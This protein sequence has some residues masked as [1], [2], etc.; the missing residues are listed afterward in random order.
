MKKIFYL[1]V[2]VFTLSM[3]C[4]MTVNAQDSFADLFGTNGELPA[5]PNVSQTN[6]IIYREGYRSS[7]LEM[8]VFD[9]ASNGDVNIVWNKSLKLS[10]N[11]KYRNDCKFYYDST[12]NEWIKFETGYNKISD[13]ATSVYLSNL[14]IY[15]NGNIYASGKDYWNLGTKYEMKIIGQSTLEVN[16]SISLTAECHEHQAYASFINTD[17]ITWSCTDSKIIKLLPQG[18]VAY[19]KALKPGTATITATHTASGISKSIQILVKDIKVE[20]ADLYFVNKGAPH[21]KYYEFSLKSEDEQLFNYEPR[22]TFEITNGENGRVAEIQNINYQNNTFELKAIKEGICEIIAKF[23]GQEKARAKIVV[24]STFEEYFAQNINHYHPFTQ[25]KFAYSVAVDLFTEHGLLNNAIAYK[26]IDNFALRV[27]TTENYNYMKAYYEMLLLSIITKQYADD[28]YSESLVKKAFGL[29]ESIVGEVADVKLGTDMK[30]MLGKMKA[31]NAVSLLLSPSD[32]TSV[33]FQLEKD[34]GNFKSEKELATALATQIT[35]M[36]NREGLVSCLKL[37]AEF[38]KSS[39]EAEIPGG[40]YDAIIKTINQIETT[41]VYIDYSQTGNLDVKSMIVNTFNDFTIR[42]WD[43]MG[44]LFEIVANSAVPGVSQMLLARDATS[45]AIECVY[46]CGNISDC[47]WQLACIDIIG[48][49]ADAAFVRAK[50]NY[51][52][53]PTLNNAKAVLGTYD[54]LLSTTDCGQ[55]QL[56]LFGRYHYNC[57]IWNNL[58]NV[59]QK[60][61]DY[62]TWIEYAE[63][64]DVGVRY[65]WWIKDNI[66]LEYGF[67]KKEIVPVWEVTIAD[68]KVTNTEQSVIP[69]NSTYYFKKD[70]PMIP[71]SLK[72]VFYITSVSDCYY[73]KEFTKPYKPT[74]ITEP[75]TLYRKVTL[76][77]NP[78]IVNNYLNTDIK[79]YIDGKPIESYNI[80][81]NTVVIVENLMEYGFDV[82]WDGAKRTLTVTDGK[83]DIFSKFQ[84]GTSIGQIGVPMGYVYKTDI[85]TY[86]NGKQV[87]AYNIGGMTAIQIDDL[88]AFGNVK[89]DGD[90]RTISFNR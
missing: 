65:N 45:F 64:T 57:G 58:V 54:F 48:T 90:E 28:E 89:W 73:D 71:A 74:T 78:N 33:V 52:A 15:K 63:S 66:A 85:K 30:A 39:G 68:G 82:L 4:C 60:Q 7:R 87:K 69:Y 72:D 16:K 24:I 53:N 36:Q 59:D 13:Y 6:Y 11:S 81:G 41:E 75:L 32:I 47:V 8:V 79:A 38:C 40:L 84:H 9:I 70:S 14:D 35:I 27:P 31:S 51:N 21:K 42:L 23:E 56:K 88:G 19:V 49:Y 76:V 77:K 5:F 80:D 43:N 22:V 17:N 55:N 18:N 25:D 46:P 83:K 2:L 86:V 3:F 29:A 44:K 62:E 12:S 1:F 50:N 20:L 61:S 10:D 34:I 26:C 37:M 67:E